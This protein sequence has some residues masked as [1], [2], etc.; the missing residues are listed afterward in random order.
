MTDTSTPQWVHDAVFYQIFPDRFAISPALAKPN[1]L[2][3][4]DAAPTP[5]G[6]KGGDLLGTAEHLD[7]LHDLGITAL[8]FTPVFQS[9]CNHRYH[10]HD[11]YLIDPL[12]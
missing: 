12:L 5:R 8:Y 9:A 4:W 11:Y 10:T 2:E 1:N 6:Y 7:Y 3:P